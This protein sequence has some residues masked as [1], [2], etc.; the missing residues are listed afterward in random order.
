MAKKAVSLSKIITAMVTDNISSRGDLVRTLG[1]SKAAITQATSKLFAKDLL[2]EQGRFNKSQFGRK[3]IKLSVKPDL[4]YFIGTDLE[5]TAIRACILNPQKKVVIRAKR[6]VGPRWS[7]PRI[8]SV[9]TEMLKQLIVDAQIDADKICCLGIGLPGL[10]LPDKFQ[11]RAYLPPGNWVELNVDSIVEELKLPTFVANNLICL[12][13]FEQKIG[14]AE[15]HNSFYCLLIRYGVAITRC[16]NGIISTS[17]EI[18]T[19]ELGHVR[20][21]MDGEKCICGR[22][23]CLDTF[24]SGRT[25][26]PDS[27]ATE[28]EFNS[29]LIKRAKYLGI[30]LSN[31]LKVFYSPCIVMNGIYNDYEPIFKKH[32]IDTMAEELS[33]LKVAPPE[34]I[35]ASP[36]EMKT[37]I[38][39]AQLA[40]NNF[41]E[42][43]CDKKIFAKK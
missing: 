32:L 38:G 20:I 28:D 31:L 14:Q 41:L 13:E 36:S 12:T 16:V 25:W 27:F 35:F 11:T 22:K 29:E 34:V 4:A 33:G 39:A 5:G 6:A 10:V 8:L 19:G 15:N 18:A 2:I 9:W 23:G 37:S 1:L 43:Y 40:A 42:Q 26:N 17:D 3:T 30:G 24:V 7:R 21:A